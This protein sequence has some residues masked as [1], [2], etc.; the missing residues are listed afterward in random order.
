MHVSA[1]YLTTLKK[2]C[3]QT[4]V[5]NNFLQIHA[6]FKLWRLT[7]WIRPIWI[8][9]NFVRLLNDDYYHHPWTNIF[10]S[11]MICSKYF[12]SWCL[13]GCHSWIKILFHFFFWKFCCSMVINLSSMDEHLFFFNYVF[14][15]NIDN[16]FNSSEKLHFIW[17]LFD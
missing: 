12:L 11:L 3:K 13:L 7:G 8:K 1:W 6:F 9:I 5:F 10:F 2:F 17:I 16:K 14:V 15:L 4:Q